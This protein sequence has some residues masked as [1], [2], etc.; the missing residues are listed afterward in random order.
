[1][2][3]SLYVPLYAI[4]SFYNRLAHCQSVGGAILNIY[5][6]YTYMHALRACTHIHTRAR[7]LAHARYK[8]DLIIS[9]G[10]ANANDIVA[11]KPHNLESIILNEK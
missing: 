8:S 4:S 10:N 2:T 6:K 7:T 1:M 5:S 11:F 3:P 9:L